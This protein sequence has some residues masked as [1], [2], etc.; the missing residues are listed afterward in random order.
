[1][2]NILLSVTTTTGSDWKKMV[3]DINKL[4]IKEV[5]LF[6]TAI[7]DKE[8]EELY[9]LLENSTIDSIPF[10]H[11]RSDML[12][13]ELKYLIK[14]YKTKVF[15]IHSEQEFPFFYDYS[16]YRDV[17]YIE[18]TPSFLDEEELKKICWN[19]SRYFSFRK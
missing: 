1:M 18:N 7:A 17:I 14:K 10:V 4:K 6:P 8:R 3:A 13:S 11:L 16:K 9:Q 15:N 12:P 2:K 19:L 5:A